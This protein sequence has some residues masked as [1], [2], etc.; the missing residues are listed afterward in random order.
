MPNPATTSWMVHLRNQRQSSLC[1]QG[2]AP[3]VKVS[4]DWSSGGIKLTNLIFQTFDNGIGARRIQPAS[5]VPNHVAEL[6]RHPPLLAKGRIHPSL[7]IV[8]K[9]RFVKLKGLQ[10][11]DFGCQVAK[12]RRG[13]KVRILHDFAVMWPCKHE[14]L[15]GS[16]SLPAEHNSPFAIT[17]FI[18]KLGT[19]WVDAVVLV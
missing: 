8:S 11:T 16:D 13:R 10:E 2:P 9:L 12:C 18:L 15:A 5:W 6:I 3:V 1:S 7:I 19:S 14:Q 17:Q 4:W